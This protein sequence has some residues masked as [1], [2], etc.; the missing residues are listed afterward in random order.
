MNKT[1]AHCK[2]TNVELEFAHIHG[3]DRKKVVESIFEK[4]QNGDYIEIDTEKIEQEINKVSYR[5]NKNSIFFCQHWY[6]KYDSKIYGE[7]QMNKENTSKFVRA[8][9]HKRTAINDIPDI[10]SEILRVQRTLLQKN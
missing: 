3:K 7:K 1:C 5:I 4:Q 6:V 10:K 8:S 9:I 2:K